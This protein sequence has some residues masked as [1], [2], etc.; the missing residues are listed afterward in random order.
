ME[1]EGQMNAQDIHRQDQ[2]KAAIRETASGVHA[3]YLAL[4]TEGFTREQAF[5]LTGIYLTTMLSTAL[6]ST[7]GPEKQ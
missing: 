2:L 3:F 6:G 5:A 7:P 1:D 4:C